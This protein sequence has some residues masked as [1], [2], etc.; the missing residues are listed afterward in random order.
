MSRPERNKPI[1]KGEAAE[2]EG[3]Q[4]TVVTD[5]EGA[6]LSIDGKSVGT[7]PWSGR[8]PAGAIIEVTARE[9]GYLTTTRIIRLDSDGKQVRVQLSPEVEEAEGV[10]SITSTPWAY[11]AVDGRILGQVTPVRLTLSAGE[12]TFVLEN[13]EVGWSVKRTVT[14]EGGETLNL[15]VRR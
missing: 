9:T 14:V 12:H 11:V 3:V 2:A 13:P 1:D 5:P 8:A 10:V 4:V 7:A 6:Q 15:D